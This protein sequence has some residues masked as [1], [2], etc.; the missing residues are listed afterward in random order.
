MERIEV[1]AS[2]S[3]DILIENGKLTHPVRGITI[4]GNFQQLLKQI[5]GIGSDLTFFGGQGAPTIRIAD[6]PV[7][8]K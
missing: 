5:N 8:G 7:S 2:R 4:A 6:I 1:N 3:Y